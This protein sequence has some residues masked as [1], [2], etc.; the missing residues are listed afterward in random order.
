MSSESERYS[1]FRARFD[2]RD[3]DEATTADLPRRERNL[4]WGWRARASRR[5]VGGVTRHPRR[6]LRREKGRIRG[7]VA[8]ILSYFQRRRALRS[9]DGL[10]Q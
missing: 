1:M 9:E 4:M 3:R 7:V 5:W 8:V 6:R 2:R 10:D